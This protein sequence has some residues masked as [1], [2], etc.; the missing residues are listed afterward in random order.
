MVRCPNLDWP[1][2]IYNCLE[3]DCGL[4]FDDDIE[5]GGVIVLDVVVMVDDDEVYDFRF[6]DV[7]EVNFCEG[8]VPCFIAALV[9]VDNFDADVIVAVGDGVD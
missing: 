9:S 7:G 1:K 3:F 2:S 6:L 4:R 5:F 8:S